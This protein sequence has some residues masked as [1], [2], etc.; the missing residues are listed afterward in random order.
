MNAAAVQHQ[1]FVH[2]IGFSLKT[3]SQ[4]TQGSLT[5]VYVHFE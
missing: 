4:S 3:K 2:L 5:C 1:Q